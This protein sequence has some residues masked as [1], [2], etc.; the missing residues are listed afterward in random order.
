MK[1][2]ERRVEEGEK[3]G[4][5]KIMLTRLS[6]KQQTTLGTSLPIVESMEDGSFLPNRFISLD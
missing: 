2:G 4:L 3:D 5:G 1:E 6:F